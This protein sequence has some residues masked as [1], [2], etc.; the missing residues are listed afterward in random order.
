MKV[1][2]VD[3]DSAQEKGRRECKVEMSVRGDLWQRD[4][5]TCEREGLLDG[6]EACYDLWFGFSSTN[7]KTGS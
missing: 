5:S 7:K 3:M 6:S 2:V 1:Q 4:S